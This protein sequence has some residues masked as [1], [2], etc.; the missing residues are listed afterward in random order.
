MKILQFHHFRGVTV[1]ESKMNW[2][3]FSEKGGVEGKTEAKG[4][5][6]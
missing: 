5:R 3:R 2:E 6:D 1:R 4:N